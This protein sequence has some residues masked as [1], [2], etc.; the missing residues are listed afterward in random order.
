METR[1]DG[2][3]ALVTGG[4]R[5]I[6]KAIAAAFAAA[7]A[8]V[9]ITSRKAEQLEAAAGEIG[10]ACAW[11]AGNV[12]APESAEAVVAATVEQFG[13]V[14]ILVNNAATNP[15]VGPMIEVDLGRWDKTIQVNLT[16]P[17]LWTQAVWNACMKERGGAV[18]N[19]ASVGGLG[20]SGELAVYNMTKAAL[21]HTTKQLAAELAPNVRVNAVAPGL[22]KTDFARL[23]WEGD[24]GEQAAHA[25]PLKRLGEV[26]DI[27]N[28]AMYLCSDASGWV[29]GQTIVIA[30]G[31]T[32]KY[33]TV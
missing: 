11:M 10:G 1:L 18:L 21:I 15:Y 29:T 17:L 4:S 14:D 9:M 25:Y 6:G 26:D 2:R 20:T 19:V 33:M 16:A 12:G 13:G 28:A 31:A 27:A 5:G 32:V 7:G 30:G 23:L 22:I 8:N 24:R 3:T